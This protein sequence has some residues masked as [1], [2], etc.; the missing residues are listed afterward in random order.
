MLTDKQSGNENQNFS[1]SIER[2]LCLTASVSKRGDD[3]KKEPHEHMTTILDDNKT[4]VFVRTVESY[5]IEHFTNIG[6]ENA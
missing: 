3:Y 1:D 2:V 6:A 4:V 5:C